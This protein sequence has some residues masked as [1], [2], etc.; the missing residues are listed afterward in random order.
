MPTQSDAPAEEYLTVDQVADE[1]G[2]SAKWVANQVRAGRFPHVRLGMQ[3]PP[4]IRESR[5]VRFTRGQLG[6][7]RAML[8]E[9]IPARQASA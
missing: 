8:V 7:I 3:P 4:G 9:H 6:E 1:L 5:P 2:M